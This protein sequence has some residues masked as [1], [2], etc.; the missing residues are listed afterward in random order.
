MQAME[1]G[2]GGNEKGGWL[3]QTFVSFDRFN[4]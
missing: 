4:P 2:G 3:C 1:G